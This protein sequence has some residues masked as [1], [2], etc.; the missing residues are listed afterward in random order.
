[1][2]FTK[3]TDLAP[4]FRKAHIHEVV[5]EH[6]RM[7]S[8]NLMDLWSLWDFRGDWPGV[9][10]QRSDVIETPEVIR[11]RMKPA[12]NTSEPSGCC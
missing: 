9:V 8:Y 6:C 12:S 1:M 5:L 7:L 4:A 2:Y 11:Q 10:D 3:Y